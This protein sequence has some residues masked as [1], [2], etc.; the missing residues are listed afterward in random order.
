MRTP[1]NERGNG[2]WLGGQGDRDDQL[3]SVLWAENFRILS[4]SQANLETMMKELI[5][6]ADPRKDKIDGF[7]FEERLEVLGRAIER[8][9]R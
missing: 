3:R 5:V 8:N 6:A 9:G 2:L 1:W 7:S 4:D